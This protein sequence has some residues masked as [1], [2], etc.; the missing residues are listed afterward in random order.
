MSIR[1]M[2]RYMR[3]GLSCVGRL[4][5][6]PIETCTHDM[7]KNNVPAGDICHTAVSIR[8]CSPLMSCTPNTSPARRHSNRRIDVYSTGDL[9]RKMVKLSNS[10]RIG[11]VVRRGSRGQDQCK[12][13]SL[14]FRRLH[15]DRP[16][17]TTHNLLHEV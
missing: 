11:P 6:A 12:R 10:P 16:I 7:S 14:P 15:V 8:P 9:N 2:S 1:L 3:S 13:A 4:H 17:V 5:T